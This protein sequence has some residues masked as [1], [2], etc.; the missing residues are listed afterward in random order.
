MARGVNCLYLADSLTGRLHFLG[1][2]GLY[3]CSLQA[4][5]G[6]FGS[7][8]LM[9]Q[10]LHSSLS[11]TSLS[12]PGFFS[13]SLEIT[14]MGGSGWGGLAVLPGDSK[15][16]QISNTSFS[17]RCYETQCLLLIEM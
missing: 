11:A 15:Y 14:P 17:E 5:T 9:P 7:V 12:D 4:S 3:Q 16:L 8:L 2:P 1:L 6:N 10:A 13:R